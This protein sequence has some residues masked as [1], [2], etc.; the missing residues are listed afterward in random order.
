MTDKFKRKYYLNTKLGDQYGYTH[1]IYTVILFRKILGI[2]IP[3][4]RYT[5]QCLIDQP[6]KSSYKLKPNTTRK[7]RLSNQDQEN[8]KYHLDINGIKSK[9]EEDFDPATYNVMDGKEQRKYIKE[10]FPIGMKVYTNLNCKPTECTV[11]GYEMKYNGS[12]EI[13]NL[14]TNYNEIEK[15]YTYEKEG[16]TSMHPGWF[17]P[18][19]NRENNLDALLS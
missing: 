6:H 17:Y 11:L 1:G 8:A 12:G 2:Y 10:R 5:I 7:K 13:C 3:I 16:N 18:K 19:S 15:S 9:Y 14:L 4:K